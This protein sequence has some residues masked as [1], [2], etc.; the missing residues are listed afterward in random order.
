MKK[1]IFALMASVALV[2][3]GCNKPVV[4]EPVVEPVEKPDPKPDP[5]PDPVPEEYFRVTAEKNVTMPIEGGTFTIKLSSTYSWDISVLNDRANTWV[6]FSPLSGPKGDYEITVTVAAN[7]EYDDREATVRLK[8]SNND[9]YDIVVSQKCA[10]ALTV[11]AS[12]ND[13]P[14]EGGTL[15]ITVQSNIDFTYQI[16]PDCA[17]WVSEAS[18]KAL[19]SKTLRFN[20]AENKRTSARSG[21]IT[22]TSSKGTETIRVNQA[23]LVPSIVVSKTQVPM[24]ADGGSFTVDVTS[25]MDAVVT[26]NDSWIHETSTKATSTNTFSFSVDAHGGYDPRVGTITFAVEGLS[27]TV[28]VEQQPS[29]ALIISMSEYEVDCTGETFSVVVTSNQAVRFSAPDPWIAVGATKALNDMVFVVG[30]APNDDMVERRGTITFTSEDGTQTQTLV[31]KQRGVT[32]KMWTDWDVVDLSADGVAAPVQ[33]FANVEI[34]TEIVGNDDGWFRITITDVPDYRAPYC[35]MV[36]ATADPNYTGIHRYCYVKYSNEAFGIGGMLKVEQDFLTGFIMTSESAGILPKEGGEFAVAMAA[37]NASIKEIKLPSWIS[38]IQTKAVTTDTL[39]FKAAPTTIKY[40]RVSTVEI[41]PDRGRSLFVEIIQEGDETKAG[42]PNDEIWYTMYNNHV[43]D[44]SEFPGLPFDQQ[45][46]SITYEDG[47]GKIKLAGPVKNVFNQSMSSIYHFVLD[48][49]YKRRYIRDVYLPDCV[50]SIGWRAFLGDE[51]ESFRVP[52]DLKMVGTEAF[53]ISNVSKF[54]GKSTSTDGKGIVIGGTFYTFAPQANDA[55][56]DVPQGITEIARGAF[57]FHKNLKKVTFP[58]GLKVIGQDS[59]SNCSLEYLTIP[60]SVETIEY[61]AFSD[62]SIKKFLGDSKFVSADG[63]YLQSDYPLGDGKLL[64]LFAN[65]SGVENYTIPEGVNCLDSYSFSKNKDIKYI[66]LPTTFMRVNG[67]AFHAVTSL[68]GVYGSHVSPD[69]RAVI[70]NGELQYVVPAGLKNLYVDATVKSIG[71]LSVNNCADLETIVINDGVTDIG[72][73][74]FTDNPKLKS[75]TLPASLVSLGY[76]PFIS[77]P[78]LTDVWV[79]SLDPPTFALIYK[80]MQS[81]KVKYHVPRA[82]LDR[83]KKSVYWQELADRIVGY[84]YTDLPGSTSEYYAST[85]Y[86][87]DG[88]VKTLQNATRGHGIDIV[89]MGDGYT[90]TMIADGTYDAG[91]KRIH[92]ALFDE[93]PFKS[94]RDCFNVYQVDVVSRN[95]FIGD[96]SLTALNTKFV[97]GTEL[98]GSDQA[99]QNYAKAAISNFDEAMIIVLVNEKNKLGGTCY[100]YDGALDQYASGLSISYFSDVPDPILFSGIVNH[101]AVGHGFG[102]LGDEYSY[103]NLGTFIPGSD[104][105]LVY[106][107]TLGWYSNVDVNGDPTQIKWA[108]FISDSRYA[109]SGVGVFE[110][111]Y[112][113]WKGI[114]RPSDYSMMR[115]NEGGFNVPSREAIWKRIQHLSNGA[116]WTYSYEDF[117]KYDAV[118]LNKAAQSSVRNNKGRYIMKPAQH[119]PPVLRGK[120]K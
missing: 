10:E 92:D 94:Y 47:I 49:D 36:Y 76:D 24:G 75:I 32:P 1:Y 71:E 30:V 37:S 25:N 89:I 39:Y 96:G 48:E 63:L 54:T 106:H 53:Y 62:N 11:T 73:Y 104:S 41:V 67:E 99:V 69:N 115:Y 93:E 45:V 3:A 5:E 38:Q 31:V 111:A 68:R 80:D 83:Y 85:D 117:V 43:L 72:M 118:N 26:V 20:I 103:E 14:V 2:L 9:L 66:T 84:D 52:D 87:A 113:Y 60:A 7:S 112:T 105:R 33:I 28:T 8:S 57:G 19:T 29:T 98:S 95:G 21:A 97:V 15:E 100:M 81:K 77:S 59:F 86:S 40:R 82:S 119:C 114:Y 4:D 109:N 13:F 120:R 44:F 16:A 78:E 90:D 56:Y 108:K 46:V 55:S 58:E 50:Q 51:M 18:T 101:E 91:M 35:K 12:R 23:A 70:V 34:Q 107:E 6:M 61:N 88:R 110:G 65:G 64:T 27:Q 116:G 17:D 22:I 102:K 74:A 42:V 79:R